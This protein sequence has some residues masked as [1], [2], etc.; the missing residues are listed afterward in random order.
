M[1]ETRTWWNGEPC[2][3]RRGTVVVAPATQHH[4]YWAKDLIG[5]RVRV[6][7]VIYDG[8]MP[9]YIFDDRGQGWMKVTDGRGSPRFGHATVYADD[10]TWEPDQSDDVE[11]AA[12]F[13]R[14]FDENPDWRTREWPYPATM[15]VPLEHGHFRRRVAEAHGG[16]KD[17]TILEAVARAV[18]AGEAWPYEGECGP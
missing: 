1:S 5:S 10:A 6:V 2:Y 8:Q 16:D 14:W 3:A 9:L 18:A 4:G 13:V 12:W 11:A 15:A 7:S 17:Y